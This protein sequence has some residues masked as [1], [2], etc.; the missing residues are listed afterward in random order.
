[1]TTNNESK[2]KTPRSNQV[3]PN[4]RSNA[5]HPLLMLSDEIWGLQ[6][7]TARLTAHIARL[8]A[9]QQAPA[10]RNLTPPTQPLVNLQNA[11]NHPSDSS[12]ITDAMWAVWS[13]DLTK[14]Y[15][16]LPWVLLNEPFEVKALTTAD[17]MLSAPMALRILGP[18]TT[19][20][21]LQFISNSTIRATPIDKLL[22]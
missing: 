10:P 12:S 14:K 9:Q 5:Q 20:G 2:Q 3:M 8:T 16:H 15:L 1:M 7:Q 19:Q 18:E 6:S 21:A 17:L 4:Q 11:G 13:M 22:L